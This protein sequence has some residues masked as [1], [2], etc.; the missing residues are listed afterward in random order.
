M[1]LA[2]EI[3]DK[4]S[5][6][7]QPGKPA[8]EKLEKQSYIPVD[9]G[10]IVEYNQKG[11]VVWEW[12]SAEYF[13]DTDI[14]GRRS[15]SGLLNTR[16]HLNAFH[17]DEK[18]QVIY[19]GFRNISRIVKIKYPEKTILVAY[20]GKY[21]D[22]KRKFFTRQH[23]INIS[24][25]NYLCVFSNNYSSNNLKNTNTP[26]AERMVDDD[27]EDSIATIVMLKGAQKGR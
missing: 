12:R 27:T 6:E 14:F 2:S 17:F 8:T 22:G 11:E 4:L 1:V 21:P 16:T 25:D 24:R 20:N 18:N 9:F 13:N 15:L 7:S 23:S 19:A 10:T 26:I 3:I 5:P